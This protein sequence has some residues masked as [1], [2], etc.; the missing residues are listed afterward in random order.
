MGGLFAKIDMEQVKRIRFPISSAKWEIEVIK[1]GRE[2]IDSPKETI[3]VQADLDGHVEWNDLHAVDR[4]VCDRSEREGSMK[5]VSKYRRAKHGPLRDV[6]LGDYMPI[7]CAPELIAVFDCQGCV[8]HKWIASGSVFIEDENGSFF[9]L[10][11]FEGSW[12]ESQGQYV[13]VDHYEFRL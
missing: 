1:V 7:G 8:P 6:P 10:H 12:C 4:K 9:N 2:P 13:S 3:S 5:L 11:E